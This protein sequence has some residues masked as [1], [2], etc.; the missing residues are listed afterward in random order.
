MVFSKYYILI[1]GFLMKERSK[2]EI[3]Y[4][5]SS[6][7]P[8]VTGSCNFLCVTFPNGTSKKI[9]V[10]F[11]LFQENKFK[12]YNSNIPFNPNQID[13]VFLTHSHI[14]H[15]GRFPFMVL[16][17]YDGPIFY[18]TDTRTMMTDG[19]F[20]C[21]T[22]AERESILE[23]KKQK[24]QI[25]PLYTSLDVI[26]TLKLTTNVEYN[27][28]YTI[29]KNVSA[30]F[31][32]NGHMLGA[33]C[34]LIQLS[35]PK[36]ETI[37]LLFTGD[38]K[39]ENIFKKVP[40]M[41]KWVKELKLIIIQESTYGDSLSSDETLVSLINE[42]QTVISPVIACERTEQVLLKIKELQIDGK[43]SKNIPIYLSGSLA[44][45]YFKVYSERS[46]VDFIPENL[47][48]VT[49]KKIK[50]ESK[51]I[52]NKNVKIIDEIPSE[53]LNSK[54]PKIILTTSGMGDNGKAP[55]Y[56]SKLAMRK[57]VTILFTCYLP[58]GTL[59]YTLSSLKKGSE[60]T[61]NIFGEKVKIPIHCNIVSCNEF[62][63]H[64]RSDEL[65]EFLKQFSNLHGVF[66]THGEVIAKEF[67]SNK[68]IEE[69]NPSFVNIFDRSVFYSMSGYNIRKVTNSKFSSIESS[70]KN[71]RK[72][73]S[74]VKKSKPKYVRVRIVDFFINS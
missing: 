12:D 1:G 5:I 32:G 49:L 25:D 61:F 65:I 22:I 66:I 40:K 33:A 18:T 14:D 9:I 17:G 46:N 37:N 64:A 34:I 27:I 57:D 2:S 73:D 24:K 47:T 71:I 62:S 13:Y 43:I 31:I 45:K 6:L 16:N 10:D 51:M 3:Q 74:Q 52:Q 70:R 38:Y 20:D 56:F 53:I 41:P 4:T 67:Y 26:D 11:G 48:L 23:T 19:L 63:S 50:L 39:K 35:Y 55:L 72:K 36:C 30:T 59:G 60:Y 28:C 15:Y 8:E 21:A 68:V 54:S 7:S 42:S 69:V 29:D 44:C 58:E